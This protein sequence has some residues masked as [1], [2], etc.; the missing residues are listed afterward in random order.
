MAAVTASKLA[1]QSKIRCIGWSP[2]VWGQPLT[3]VRDDQVAERL[4]L[5]CNGTTVL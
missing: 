5:R 4:R 1:V 3:I 2:Y